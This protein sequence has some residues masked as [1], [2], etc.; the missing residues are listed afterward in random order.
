MKNRLIHQLRRLHRTP[1]G[2]LLRDTV[3]MGIQAESASVTTYFF[4]GGR[5]VEMSGKF[6]FGVGK[7]RGIKTNLIHMF[8]MSY[9]NN[10]IQSDYS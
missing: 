4:V 3:G 2:F 7:G 5:Q 1:F 6:N 8:F 10:T 9:L